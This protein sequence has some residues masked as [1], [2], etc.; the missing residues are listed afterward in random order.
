MMMRDGGFKVRT[1]LLA[2]KVGKTD[3]WLVATNLVTSVPDK[4]NPLSIFPFKI[5]LRVF[6]DIG[7]YAQAWDRDND[8]DRF[9]FD[10]GLQLSLFKETVNIYIPVLYSKVYRDYY[11]STIPESRFLKSISFNINFF[12][13]EIKKLHQE[14]EF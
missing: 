4:I 12:N 9:L 1:D 14:F 2:D 8:A 3:N 5:P 13:K 10:L 6:A 11:K 7:T